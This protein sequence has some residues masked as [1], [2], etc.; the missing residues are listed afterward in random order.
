MRIGL[1]IHSLVAGGA[2]RVMSRMA[3]HWAAKG[4]EVVLIT[5]VDD[6]IPPFYPL[7]PRVELRCL[8]VASRSHNSGEAFTH[9]F[10]RVLRLREVVRE[11]RV[12]VLISF[13]MPMNI[14]AILATTGLRVPLIVSERSDPRRQSLSRLWRAL[15]W[16]LYG[17]ADALVVQSERVLQFFP[18]RMRRT[19]RVIPNPVEVEPGQ[20]MVSE[21]LVCA[22]GRLEW[23]KGFDL[24]VHAFGLM[25]SDHPGW[26]LEIWGEGTQRK[27]LEQLC[28]ACGMEGRIRFAGVTHEPYK[29]LRRAEL[30]VLSSRFEGFPNVLCEAMA[31]GVPVISFDCSSGPREIIRNGVDGVLVPAEDT[32]ALAEEMS[33]L[34]SR[35]EERQRLAQRG[36][37]VLERFSKE[38]VMG[39][40]EELIAVVLGKR[41]GFASAGK[42]SVG[43]AR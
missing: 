27:K 24:L 21:K 37:E 2:E 26:V 19:G 28:V 13:M 10:T 6:Q 7:D 14:L 25:A 34:M 38:Q 12:Q 5:F 30:F 9:N 11:S 29:Q 35:K 42:P 40:W 16:A 1:L 31:C 3:N 43:A 8:G 17:A 4:W 32:E 33:R 36:P 22:M 39:L 20:R 41:N 18:E 15:R 23:Q